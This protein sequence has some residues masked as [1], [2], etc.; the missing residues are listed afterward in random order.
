MQPGFVSA[1]VALGASY[2]TGN[3][4]CSR[5]GRSDVAASRPRSAPKMLVVEVGSVGEMDTVLDSADGSLV[6][7]DY[8]T[9]WCGPC[10]G[11]FFTFSL[12]PHAVP[13]ET[14]S[15]RA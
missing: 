4:L 9:S 1:P 11:S 6:I 3:A 8:S 15:L 10:K 5:T 13:L 7:V 14:L 2:V 12:S